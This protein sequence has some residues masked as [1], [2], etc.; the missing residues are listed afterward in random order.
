[1]WPQLPGSLTSSIAATVAPRKTSSDRS[2]PLALWSGAVGDVAVL[3]QAIELAAEVVADDLHPG[4]AQWIEARGSGPLRRP[5]GH[6]EDRVEAVG[7]GLPGLG[8]GPAALVGEL[9]VLG[10]DPERQRERPDVIAGHGGVDGDDAARDLVLHARIRER[11]EIGVPE[12]VGTQLESL[13]GQELELSETPF[14]PLAVD[15]AVAE[16]RVAGARGGEQAKGG[17]E[18][19]VRVML[20]EVEPRSEAASRVDRQRAVALEVAK[21]SRGRVVEGEDDR[22]H[23][24]RH[25]NVAVDQLRHG[26]GAIAAGIEQLE[27]AAKA[28]ARA[29]PAAVLVGD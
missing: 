6:F 12:R 26:D 18:G 20:R 14:G 25:G 27:I 4:Q 2:R 3:L 24:D 15:A 13:I 17:A 16:E 1:M 22:R 11:G 7:Q 23:A 5:A 10:P 28:V 29:A 21:L 8:I 19:P 9:P